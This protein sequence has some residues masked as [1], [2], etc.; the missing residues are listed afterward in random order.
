MLKE[1]I[2]RIAALGTNADGAKIVHLNRRTSALVIAGQVIK[3]YDRLP[4]PVRHECHTLESLIAYVNEF[5]TTDDSYSVFL[6]TAAIVA[7]LSNEDRIEACTLSLINSD[8]WDAI[9]NLGNAITHPQFVKLMAVTL[10]GSVDP[11]L[12]RSIRRIEFANSGSGT[13]DVQRGKDT[14]GKSVES[15]VQNIADIPETFIVNTPVYQNADLR[16]PYPVEMVLEIDTVNRMFVV[17]PAPDEISKVQ[18]QANGDI[19]K[20]LRKELTATRVFEGVPQ[21]VGVEK[22]LQAD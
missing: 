15:V 1:A 16:Q 11:G 21:F 12:V 3:E 13:S 17:L 19:L 5:A 7:V 18:Q 4:P 8:R 14:M 10:R 9:A 6:G 2:D 22:L 20:R